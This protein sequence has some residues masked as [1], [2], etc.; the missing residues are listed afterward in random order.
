[1]SLRHAPI[2]LVLALAPACDAALESHTDADTADVSGFYVAPLSLTSLEA[3]ETQTAPTLS[4]S[5]DAA[6]GPIVAH[7]E[8]RREV[9]TPVD[10]LVFQE[11]VEV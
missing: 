11:Q 1:M 2:A 7:F 8:G 5:P 9:P 10:G 4:A 3:A 6:R